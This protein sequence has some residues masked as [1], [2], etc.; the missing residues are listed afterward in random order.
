MKVSRSNFGFVSAAWFM[1]FALVACGEKAFAADN[2]FITQAGGGSNHG[3][4]Y[5]PPVPQTS[6]TPTMSYVPHSGSLTA[7]PET[8]A[9]TGGNVATTLEMG[10]YN[11]VFQGQAGADN[12]SNVGIINGTRNNVGVLQAGHNL[13]SNLALVNTRGL[14]I[15]V[16]Q[17][18]GSAPVNMLIARLPNGSLLIKH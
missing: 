10:Q 16:I 6:Q 17:P 9:I 13:S 12:V 11:R 18:N 8:A 1:L 3:P 2:A 5:T 7:T 4:S 15:G 14:S